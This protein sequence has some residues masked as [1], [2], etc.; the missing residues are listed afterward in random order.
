[1]GARRTWTVPPDAGPPDGGAEDWLTVDL[2]WIALADMQAGGGPDVA[3]RL[4]LYDLQGTLVVDGET[5]PISPRY[6]T[7]RWPEGVIVADQ[8]ALPVASAQPL[9]PALPAGAYRLDIAVSD[10]GSG[11]QIAKDNVQVEMG[12]QAQ[13]LVPALADMQHAAGVT[14]GGEMRLLGYDSAYEGGQMDVA[15]YWQA[16]TAIQ[17]PYKIFAHLQDEE[18]AIVAQHDGMPYNWAYPTSLWGRR[19]VYIERISLDVPQ[20][21]AG[22]YRL[23]VG[24]YSAET[25]RLPAVD[26]DGQR[27]PGDQA[28]F[29]MEESTAGRTGD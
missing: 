28:V 8:Y 5:E 21:K 11:A 14:Y 1:V 9:D 19:E 29:E 7:S 16:L 26:L 22:P 18:G 13:P 24:V 27:L 2:T 6:P 4:A 20:A 17:H 15:L 10:L 23:A 25:G 12:E 3:C